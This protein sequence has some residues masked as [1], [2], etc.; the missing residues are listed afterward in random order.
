MG[1]IALMIHLLMLSLDGTMLAQDIGDA[2]RRHIDYAARLGH[3]TMIIYTP[4]TAAY[5]PMT[6]A[7]NLTAVPTGSRSRYTFL[8]DAY[9]LAAQLHRARPIDAITSQ[10]PF[11]TGLAGVLLK[12]RLHVPLN[13]QSHSTFFDNPHYLRERPLNRVFNRLGK[14]VVRHADTTR[15][16]NHH[17]RQKHIALG[18]PPQ[19]VGA[20]PVA[21]DLSQF[22]APIP[23]G[24][25]AAL[26]EQLGLQ[27]EH[28]VALW[29]GRPVGFKNLPMLFQAID[30][31]RRTMPALRL[32]LAGDFGHAQA[33]RERAQTRLGESAVFAG[34]VPHDALP[35][36]YALSTAYVHTSF[37]EGMP[38]VLVEASA[39]GR[40]V[41]CT[42][43]PGADM[44]VIDGETGFRTPP[45]DPAALAEKLVHLLQHPELAA[46][47]GARARAHALSAFDREKLTGELVALWERT[48]GMK[49]R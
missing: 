1:I 41:V 45:G 5:R 34:R 38:R 48:A 4:R 19:H 2:R 22:T 8:W 46:Q 39:A 29:V 17:E 25:I 36:Y 14:W 10:D 37:Y 6:L 7:P 18:L 40:P 43:I 15:A 28:P 26:R 3:I 23:P 49:D 13:V 9:R 24:E 31:A 11:A 12:Q 42:D 20:I 21:T 33:L 47:M 44:A 35:A 32:V 30:H 16:V 27:A